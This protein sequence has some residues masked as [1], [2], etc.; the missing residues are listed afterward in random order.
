MIPKVRHEARTKPRVQKARF[1]WN[2]A[3]DMLH[4]QN[5]RALTDM[6]HVRSAAIGRVE[7]PIAALPDRQLWVEALKKL[8]ST[9]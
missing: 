6:K 5:M 2:A 1:R 7:S 8:R 4:L 9:P 3:K